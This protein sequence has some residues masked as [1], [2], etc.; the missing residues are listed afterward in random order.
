MT[1]EGR[2]HSTIVAL[3]VPIMYFALKAIMPR[4]PEA[5]ISMTAGQSILTLLASLGVYKLLA[6]LFLLSFRRSKR[7][8]KWLLGPH[9]LE[10]T[11]VGYF[12]DDARH[13]V[14][15]VEIVEQD[16]GSLVLKGA[17]YSADGIMHARWQADSATVDPAKATLLYSYTCDLISKGVPH[18]GIG[19]FDLKRRSGFSS[20]DEMEGYSADLTNGLR[21]V[22]HEKKISD[23]SLNKSEA[24]PEAIKFA[25][26]RMLSAEDAG[27]GSDVVSEEPQNPTLNRTAGAAG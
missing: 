17:S 25:A 19:V 20:A 8:K 2:F 24:L 21:S 12:M 11:W 3:V 27:F 22:A 16:L 5:G 9:F 15:F 26:S 7:V 13:P 10:G 4:L 1:P 18:Q 14:Y 23:R 6:Q